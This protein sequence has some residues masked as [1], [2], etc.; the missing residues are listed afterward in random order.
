[1]SRVSVVDYGMGN[2]LSVKRSFEH[3]GTEV[4]IVQQPAAIINADYLVLPGVGAFGKAMRELHQLGLVDAIRAFSKKGNP[5]LGICLGMQMMLDESTEH[6][7]S[8]GLSLI[9]GRVEQIPNTTSDGRQHKVPHV[10][11]NRICE[12]A[13][14][15]DISKWKNTILD[16]VSEDQAFYFVHSYA[17]I[18]DDQYRLADSYYGGRR[19][20]AVIK[21]EN[22]Y[23]CQFHPEKSG[24][25]GL[26]IIRGFMRQ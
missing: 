7:D 3:C 24:L 2:I 16:Q 13:R 19:I 15:G 4:E 22:L 9:P 6:G 20:A 18:L 11:W 14:A 21:K 5:F 25:A 10:G 26:N 12:P 8:E 23:G 17:A 1:M